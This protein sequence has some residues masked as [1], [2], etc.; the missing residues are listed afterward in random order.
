MK[1]TLKILIVIFIVICIVIVA[2]S[3]IAKSY[4]TEER[5]RTYLTEAAEKSLGRKVGLGTIQV[6]IFKGISIK[7]FEIREKNSHEAFIK[8]EVFV[9]SYQLLPL[10][11]R[12]LVIDELKLVNAS[13]SVYKNADG[14]FNFSDISRR[15]DRQGPKDQTPDGSGLPVALNVRSLSLKNT[16]I[17]YAEP[18]GKLLKA[19]VIINADLGITSPSAGILSSEGSFRFTV[20]EALLKDKLRP[21]KDLTSKGTY[22]VDLDLS[23]KKVTIQEV[24]ADVAKIPIMMKG[25]ASYADLFTFSLDLNM[26]KTDLSDLQQVGEPFLPEGTALGGTA[27]LSISAEKSQATN[28]RMTFK[29]QLKLN[30]AAIAAKGYRPVFNGTI[31]F[32]PDLISLDH[33]TLSAAE[34]TADI[35]GQIKNYSQEPDI[36]INLTAKTL[37]L[38]AITVPGQKQA[39][40]KPAP[41]PQ[42][43]EG[44]DFE[45]VGNNV[46]AA[47]SVS[48]DKV[49]YKGVTVQNLRTAYDF[50]NSIF[51]ISSLTGNTLNGSFRFQSAVDLSKRGA[52]YTMNADSNGIRLEDVTAAFAPKAKDTL[53]GALYGKVEFAGAGTL[54]ENIKQN[55]RGK[56][57][58]VIKDGQIKNA[59]I[60]SGLLGFLGLQ[61]LR[62][63]SMDKADGTF[64]VSDGIFSIQSLIAGKDLILD[65]KGTISMDEQLDL[66]V[67]VKVS[68]KLAP[69]M[70]SQSSVSQFLSEGKGWTNIPLRISGTVMKPSYS[71]DMKYAGKKAAEKLQKKAEEE[72]LKALSGDKP[73]KDKTPLKEKKKGAGPEDLFKDFFK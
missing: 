19:R 13:L 68:E 1:K 55:L 9:L 14:T 51:R 64:T 45:P 66:G 35:T 29:G 15:S 25:Y 69:K 20:S 12:S 23:S 53:Y 60:S 5:I 7:D 37:N 48:I 8:A 63:I 40:E 58:F 38:D 17:D 49:L 18:A 28:S 22:K 73:K 43:R 30:N 4:L 10:L 65:E 67:L 44:Q 72:I 47:G 26:P 39:T 11:S 42:K 21:L 56:G 24:R 3:F 33:V 16:V 62:E 34:S 6:S 36:Q 57:N 61:D 2:V 32:T 52:T 41:T 59:K 31:R 70:L 71:V 27:S 54:K 46:R 50:R